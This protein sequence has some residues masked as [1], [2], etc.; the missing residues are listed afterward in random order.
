MALSK[1]H[2]TQL[3]EWSSSVASVDGL[4]RLQDKLSLRK[5]FSPEL[6]SQLR[7]LLF[8]SQP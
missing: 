8:Y 2:D 6:V 3:T 7:T 4:Y 5:Y 1:A